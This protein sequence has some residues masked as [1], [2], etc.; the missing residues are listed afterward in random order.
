MFLAR[1][2]RRRR[3]FSEL[4]V[5]KLGLDAGGLGFGLAYR[6]VEALALGANVDRIKELSA[7]WQ[8][9]DMDA[10][11]F[12]KFFDLRLYPDGGDMCA[13]RADHI[14]LQASH[15]GFGKTYL[16]AMADLLKRLGFKPG[17]L[18]GH[19]CKDLFTV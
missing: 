11:Q 5:G 7:K 2:N 16:E 4:R 12:G 13:T 10:L 3:S 14:D 8:C 18:W 17:K 9:D 1:D 15:A 6:L 19:T